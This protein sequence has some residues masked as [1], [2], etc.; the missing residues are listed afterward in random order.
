MKFASIN[1]QMDILK[2]GVQ[3]IIPEEELV[4]KLDSKRVFFESEIIDKKSCATRP[5]VSKII[6][7]EVLYDTHLK[8][9]KEIQ[10]AEEQIKQTENATAIVFK[11]ESFI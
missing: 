10:K 9:E 8:K 3:E 7:I 1:E 2:R 11:I 4:K 5:V 6:A